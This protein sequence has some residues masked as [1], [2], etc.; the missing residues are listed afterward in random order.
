MARQ[1]SKI[2]WAVAS[3]A[4]VAVGFFSYSVLSPSGREA[5]EHHRCLKREEP[6]TA[7]LAERITLKAGQAT[8]ADVRQFLA[9]NFADLHIHESTDNIS[10]GQM[11]FSFSQDGLLSDMSLEIP[12][13]FELSAA[14]SQVPQT[15]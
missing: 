14:A 5:I 3:A 1:R 9:Q 2:L 7:A 12:C 8:K 4:I 15:N 10:A 6:R 11:W 13:P